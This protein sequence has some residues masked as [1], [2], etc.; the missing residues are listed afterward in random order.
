MVKEIFNKPK[1]IL[2][3]LRNRQTIVVYFL[4][5]IVIIVLMGVVGATSISQLTNYY[6]MAKN[7]YIP[8]IEV[9]QIVEKLY[10]NRMEVEEHIRNNGNY[11]KIEEKISKNNK[12]IDSLIKAY[13]EIY[14]SP[15]KSNNLQK[16]RT[17]LV[18]Y[19]RIEE[20]VVR[21][22]RK[23]EKQ[24]ALILFIGQ[25]TEKFQTVITPMEQLTDVH[26]AEGSQLYKDAEEFADSI[27][28]FLYIAVGSAFMFTVIIGTMVGIRYMNE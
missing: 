21:L 8:A 7:R 19:Q 9:T 6:T 16:Y 22:S 24:Q 1:I 15:M 12:K 28:F 10:E 11:Q 3:R 27:R 4:L 25:S 2:L 5:L 14:S 18:A 13:S 17:D 20:L 26:L 23:N